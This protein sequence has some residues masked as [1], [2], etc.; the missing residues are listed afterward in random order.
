MASSIH[1]FGRSA[2]DVGT[3]QTG[4][5]IPAESPSPDYVVMRN[6]RVTTMSRIFR[7]R[8]TSAEATVKLAVSC[9]E[10][11][12]VKNIPIIPRLADKHFA[13]ELALTSISSL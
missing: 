5:Q 2:V 13:Y 9:L 1:H 11:T 10:N 8:W 7:A 3:D 6:S 4:A 12:L